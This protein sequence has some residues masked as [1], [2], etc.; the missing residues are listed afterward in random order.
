MKTISLYHPFLLSVFLLLGTTGIA[1]QDCD[2]VSSE[3]EKTALAEE[4]KTWY[5]TG[6]NLSL[7]PQYGHNYY[8]GTFYVQGDTILNGVKHKRL[9]HHRVYSNGDVESGLCAHIKAD[10]VNALGFDF[11]MKKGDF[12][13][14]SESDNYRTGWLVKEVADTTLNDGIRRK[15]LYLDFTVTSNDETHVVGTDIWVEGIGSLV[16]GIQLEDPTMMGGGSYE[17]HSVSIGEDYIYLKAQ[18]EKEV[19]EPI[20]EEVTITP[21]SLSTDDEINFSVILGMFSGSFSYTQQ[22]DSIV[23]NT[24][25]VG[26]SYYGYDIGISML[27]VA[28][29]LSLGTLPAGDY[30]LQ[31]TVKAMPSEKAFIYTYPFTV[32]NASH[33]LSP[34]TDNL[35]DTNTPIYD[36]TGR[37]LNGISQ[38]GIYIQGGKKWVVK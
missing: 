4:G 13:V 11:S 16:S 32:T 29:D 36:L 6:V 3:N 14:G 7:P 26:A 31:H 20:F 35:T 30:T 25:Y 24:I 22:L 5:C 8:T 1:A 9:Y 33:I 28:Y 12:K 23:G 38:K 2:V 17:L 37:K 15:C 18:D 19:V 27:P 34:T 10:T 21:Q